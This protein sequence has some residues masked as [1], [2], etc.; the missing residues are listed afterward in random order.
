MKYLRSITILSMLSLCSCTMIYDVTKIPRT[1]DNLK[2]LRE[3][4]HTAAT[5]VGY[6]QQGFWNLKKQCYRTL[7]NITTERVADYPLSMPGC[8]LFDDWGRADWREFYFLCEPK[9]P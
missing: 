6:S 5:A 9:Q 1:P 4:Q 8:Q 2:G 3:C 7:D